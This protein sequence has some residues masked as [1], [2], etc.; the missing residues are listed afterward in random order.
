MCECESQSLRMFEIHK[1]IHLIRKKNLFWCAELRSA[2][3]EKSA[4]KY[5]FKKHF[6]IDKL[7]GCV[8]VNSNHS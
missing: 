5:K 4:R 6:T 8:I 3:D 2:S 7:E 1:P